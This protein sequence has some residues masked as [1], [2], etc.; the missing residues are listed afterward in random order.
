MP[1]P[2]ATL[3]N[4]TA[5]GD[6]VTAPGSPTNLVNCLP[7]ACLGDVVAGAV[8]TGAISV[9]TAVTHL[10][11]CRPAACMGSMV[12][13]VNPITGIPVATALAVVPNV[14]RIV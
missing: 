2:A 5:T 8:C 14:N 11:K 1:T 6:V 3:V 10:V 4:A 12:T 13:G 7:E 9:T